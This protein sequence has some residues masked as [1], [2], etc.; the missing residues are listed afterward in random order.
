MDP[1]FFRA[2]WCLGMTYRAKRM[3]KEA[4]AEHQKM[5]DVSGGWPGAVASLGVDYGVSSYRDRALEILNELKER[6]T[7]FNSPNPV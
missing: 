2:Q 7:Q 4:I 5:I 1:N 3:Y 6:A